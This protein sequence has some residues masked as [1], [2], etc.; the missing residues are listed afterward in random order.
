MLARTRT[1]INV[2]S[3]MILPTGCLNLSIIYLGQIKVMDGVMNEIIGECVSA[4]A[5][6]NSSPER[7][8]A[9]SECSTKQKNNNEVS[10]ADIIH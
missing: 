7:V 1:R 10:H 8:G 9:N 5:Q 3:L 2:T 4:S 6:E